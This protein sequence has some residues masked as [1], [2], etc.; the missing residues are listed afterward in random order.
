MYAAS[1]GNTLIVD[2]LLKNGA[3]PSI[4]DASGQ[5]VRGVRLASEPSCVC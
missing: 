1:K 4:S 2:L 3:N 5:C